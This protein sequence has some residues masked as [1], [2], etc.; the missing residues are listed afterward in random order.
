[1][2]VMA[3]VAWRMPS[4][5]AARERDA[6]L[7]NLRQLD[8]AIESLA[9]ERSWKRGQEVQPGAVAPYMKD[10]MIPSCPSGGSYVVPPLGQNPTCSV[11]GDMLGPNDEPRKWEERYRVPSS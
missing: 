4:W 1:M 8:G 9:A 11:H 5:H 6:C 7:E 2:A 3:L 10:N